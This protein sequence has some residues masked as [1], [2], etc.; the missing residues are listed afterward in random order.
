MKKVIVLSLALIVVI[1]ALAFADGVGAFSAFKSGIGARALAMGGAFVAVA[2]DSTAAC[3]NPAGLAQVKDTRIGGMSTD[4]FGLGYTHQ[5]VNAITEFSGFGIGLS[6]ERA[7][8]PGTQ[9]DESGNAGNE[10]TWSE[11]L[12]LG[13][14][15]VDIEGIGLVGANVKY[16]MADSGLG[17]SASG[18]GF[19]LGL[20]FNL[21]DMFTIGVSAFDLGNTQIAWSTGANDAVTG[22]YKVGTAV[23]LL[24]GSL[25]LA[26]DL[27]F[28]G[29]EMGD[30]H[31]GL[32]YKLIPE[33]AL[34]GGV[35]LA[36]NFSEYSFT[37]GAGLNV[38]G[39]NVDAAYLLNEDLGN[40]LVLS[41]EFS[42]SSLFGGGE[43]EQQPAPASE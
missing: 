24:D 6:Y 13:T 27:D 41:A 22:V 37:V 31:V 17:D 38:A 40:T 42:L 21:G 20:L 1:S 19:D 4:L 18:F 8:V 12:F 14:V 9:V 25:I 36:D 26:G 3:W 29:M 35:L 33:L 7:A 23:K 32:E 28:V 39:L 30:A 11:S 34:R 15:S 16:Y 43:Q 5:F 2:D 10:F